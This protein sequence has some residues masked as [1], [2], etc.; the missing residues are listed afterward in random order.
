MTLHETLYKLFLNTQYFL[1]LELWQIITRYN[2]FA[3]VK[4]VLQDKL[5]F[6]TLCRVEGDEYD[7]LKHFY[8]TAATKNFLRKWKFEYFYLS[9]SSDN[10]SEASSTARPDY[11]P[12]LHNLEYDY[13]Y[14]C[15]PV[16]GRFWMFDVDEEQWVFTTVDKEIRF[17]YNVDEDGFYFYETDLED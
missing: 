7:E 9:N 12:T 6:P 11:C 5:V 10:E 8:Y 17:S 4:R 14:E 16:K 3:T 2:K 15:N 1:P 13:G